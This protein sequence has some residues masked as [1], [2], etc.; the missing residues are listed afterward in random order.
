MTRVSSGSESSSPGS[1]CSEILQPMSARRSLDIESANWCKP[2][3]SREPAGEYCKCAGLTLD[4]ACRVGQLSKRF[5]R[6]I[7]VGKRFRADQA[8]RSEERPTLDVVFCGVHA[9][10]RDNSAL[11]AIN[12]GKAPRLRASA[13]DD[14]VMPDRKSDGLESQIVL[15]RP[16]PGNGIIDLGLVGQSVR[17][18][19][20]LIMGVLHRFYADACAIG[21]ATFVCG[22]IADRIDVG[23]ACASERINACTIAPC[24]VGRHQR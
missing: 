7:C 6:N 4:R 9:I 19:D 24:R 21:V 13:Y 18:H 1:S 2:F 5:K 8:R 20:R 23:K 15:V 17:H 14:V 3:C 10:E 22:T 12:D 16:E 11:V